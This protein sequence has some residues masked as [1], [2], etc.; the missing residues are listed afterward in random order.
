MADGKV[1]ID[2][3]LDNSGLEKGLKN[4]KGNI[5][6]GLA[7]AV[8]KLGG[9]IVAAF[10]VRALVSF[11]KECVELGSAI[12]EV[13]NVV[14]VA[15]GD[16]A[17]KIEEFADT[18]VQSFGMSKL[19]AKKTASTYMA[20]ARG[21]GIADEAASDMAISLTGL[22]GDVASFFNISQELADTKLKSVFTGE[23]ETLKDL[24]IVMTQTNLKA[25]ALKE[26]ITKDISAMSQA[27]LVSLRYKFVMNQLSLANGDF[28]RTSDSWANQTRILSEQWKEF[29]SI[30]GD[31]LIKVFTPLLKTLNEIVGSLIQVA[32]TVNQVITALFG[33]TATE[34]AKA[35]ENTKQ[36]NSAI[37]ESVE[38]QEAMTDA[39]N[40]TEKAQKKS[41]AS[42]DEINK[43]SGETANT[44]SNGEPTGSIPPISTEETA[45]EAEGLVQKFLAAF[46]AIKQGVAEVA[47]A[48]KG[49]W[50]R[51]SQN[52]STALA[53]IK[54]GA[55]SLVE[56]FMAA[57][58]DIAN[59]GTPLASW[60]DEDV[61]PLIQAFVDLCGNTLSGLLDSFSKVFSDVWDLVIAPVL[62]K[63]A[64]DILP[65]VAQVATQIISAFG[66]LVDEVKRVFDMIWSQGIAPALAVISEIWSDCWDSITAA[67]EKW[68]APIFENVKDA[69]RN[70]ADTLVNIWNTIIKPVW[71]T[72]LAAVKT[73]W[74]EHLHPLFDRILDFIGTLINNALRIY[75][76]FILPIVNWL[77]TVLGPAF[78]A[79]F[80][81]VSDL[82]MPILGG[83]IDAVSG[84]V[85][86]FTGLSN[87]ITGIFTQ[88]WELA[89]Q[90]LQEIVTG[91]FDAISG[92]FTGV[93]N[94]IIAGVEG[95]VNFFISGVNAIIDAL[96]SISFDV[97]DWVPL[98]G[99]NSFGLNI[100]NVPALS[101]PRLAQGAVI[102]PNREFMAVL[103]DQ[104]SG[105][106]IEAPVSEIEAA[107][108]R[109]VVKAGLQT[110]GPVQIELIVS[111]K[112]G[113][114][115]EMKFEL[116]RESKRQGVKLV[117]GV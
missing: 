110:N 100:P 70:T 40:D 17:Y 93:L 106:N 85:E 23:T 14:D 72:I 35:G 25:Y 28:A 36:I 84:I 112:A 113:M 102:P 63:W 87:F 117:Q 77:V 27:E 49:V 34:S 18:A 54:A 83:I 12:T 48:F 13:Q 94:G 51:I 10:S 43:L 38:N 31:S 67:W 98:I 9:L 105:T 82:V 55:N 46:E 5:S 8:K 104:K 29:M 57:W 39:V 16:M 11:G 15:F 111:T 79:V 66:V 74:E 4:I 37:G 30:V 47:E 107:V 45:A 101:I 76:E 2:T 108:A 78:T 22:S 91:V 103:G 60:F 86:A 92:A 61:I 20:M 58:S 95:F 19:S 53:E 1:T 41:I 21:M 109:G 75:N 33:S 68:G 73:L 7:P 56:P 88:D 69:I 116:D 81:A 59:L 99:G 97:P 62:Q 42:F 24:G 3:T 52:V 26:G 89:W 6:D 64:T 65:L 44:S 32:T 71:D 115:R 50:D 114:A 90:G 96:N 80:Q